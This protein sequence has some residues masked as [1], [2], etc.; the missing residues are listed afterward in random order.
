MVKG[1]EIMPKPSALS[2]EEQTSSLFQPDPFWSGEFFDTFKRTAYLEP[3]KILMLA[4]LQDAIICLQKYRASGSP[5]NKRLF[6][7]AKAWI[8]SEDWDWPFSFKNVCEA[9]SLNPGYLRRGLIRM[10]HRANGFRFATKVTAS[11]V[12]A[13]MKLGAGDRPVGSVSRLARDS[14]TARV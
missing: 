12:T 6:D 14:N 5:G 3:E 1:D 10:S 2:L 8:Q 7:Q 13:G 4:V 9:V 11:A